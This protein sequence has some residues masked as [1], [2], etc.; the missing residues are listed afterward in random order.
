MRLFPIAIL[1]V[2]VVAACG[3]GAAAPAVTA[4]DLACA[5]EFCAAY[6]ADW[7]VVDSG[8]T[9]LSFSHSEAPEDVVATV[10]G[11]NMESLVEANGG[12]WPASPQQVVEI[13][14][15]AV[16]GGDAELGRLEFRDDGSIESFGVFGTGRMWSLLLPTDAVR[17]VGVEVR[18]P[19]SSWEDHARVF[20]DGVQ[21]LP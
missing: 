16:D 14:W 8:A 17:A 3:G 13:F 19:N 6:P 18:A 11:V 21:V 10:G 2:L 12:Q 20:L 5:D 1:L 15:G 9:F 7:S 4:T